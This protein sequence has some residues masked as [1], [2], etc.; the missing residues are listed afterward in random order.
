MH[1]MISAVN[2]EHTRERMYNILQYAVNIVDLRF[3]NMESV[4]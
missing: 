3:E 2:Y 4:F 1:W